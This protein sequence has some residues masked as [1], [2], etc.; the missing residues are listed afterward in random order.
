MD[1]KLR[2]VPQTLKWQV[3]TT[4]NTFSTHT[5]QAIS[6]SVVVTWLPQYVGM[7]IEESSLWL[8]GTPQQRIC[9]QPPY[10]NWA[11][12]I[13]YWNSSEAKRTGARHRS[14]TMHLDHPL[15]AHR[16]VSFVLTSVRCD[17]LKIKT[18]KQWENWWIMTDR[19]K[20][21]NHLSHTNMP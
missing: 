9:N 16:F 2:R 20:D 6:L 3:S 4:R 1:L 19:H 14:K 10:F 7:S 12:G 11:F 8:Y 15:T 13:H 5:T 21:A 17:L 18:R